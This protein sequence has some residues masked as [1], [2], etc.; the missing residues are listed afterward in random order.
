MLLA[1]VALAA[2]DDLGSALKAIADAAAAKHN[3]SISLSVR[4]PS[5]FASRAAGT[6]DMAGAV[7]AKPSD[8]YAWGSVTKTMTGAAIFKHI[9]AGRLTL[10]AKAAPHVDAALATAGF[11]YTMKSLFSVD[12]WAVQNSTIFDAEEVT[13][14]HLLHMVSGIRDYDTD[15]YR[16]LQYKHPL[17]DF[18]PFDLLS[19]V[20]APLM[21]KPGGPVPERPD[22]LG[23]HHPLSDFNYCSINFVLLGL[24]AARLDGAPSWREWDQSSVLPTGVRDVSFAID[25]PCA[26]YTAPVHGIDRASGPAAVDVSAISCLGGWSAGNASAAGVK[27]ARPSGG[28]PLASHTEGRT[29][30][31]AR[32]TPPHPTPPH[33]RPSC[34]QVVMSSEAAANW[35]YALYGPGERVLPA[36][37]VS[38]MLPNASQIYGLATFGFTGEYAN[39]TE[40]VAHGHLGDTY[41]FTSIVSYFPARRVAMAV[42][43]NVEGSEQ[44]APREVLCLAYNRVLDHLAGRRHPRR[45]EYVHGS[46]YESGCRCAESGAA[47]GLM[48][49]VVE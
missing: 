39:G 5:L 49:R 35:T 18:S 3:C 41:G 46:Y 8:R 15:A 44:T 40:G 2:P 33:P 48:A 27:P 11:P 42:A 4:T 24:V 36:A 1:S 38:E 45:C 37:L 47:A 16:Y 26:R 28:A 34:R 30:R 7:A 31:S 32:W 22:R 29:A 10:D 9:A 20:H 17:V 21:F 13:I 25:G 12:R 14:R 43:T 23:R 6:I 19:Y